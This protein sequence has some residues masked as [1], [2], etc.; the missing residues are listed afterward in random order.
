MPSQVFVVVD[1]FNYTNYFKL[2]VDK[3]RKEKQCL[4]FLHRWGGDLKTYT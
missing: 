3:I 2:E 1:V 4:L